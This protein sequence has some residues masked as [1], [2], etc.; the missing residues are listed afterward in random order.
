MK[1]RTGLAKEAAEENLE[2][3]KDGSG[4][5]SGIVMESTIKS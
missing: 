2:Q 5:V 3:K 4:I 1:S